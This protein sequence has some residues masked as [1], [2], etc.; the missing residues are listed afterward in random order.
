MDDES[1]TFRMH[2]AIVWLAWQRKQPWLAVAIPFVK[3][4]YEP[5]KAAIWLPVEVAVFF[6][7]S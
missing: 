1:L 2:V 3:V 4:N 5:F 6:D 7:D